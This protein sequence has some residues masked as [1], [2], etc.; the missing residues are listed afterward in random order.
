MEKTK[1]FGEFPN[2]IYI[3][4]NICVISPAL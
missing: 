4:I 3:V 2:E 1:Y